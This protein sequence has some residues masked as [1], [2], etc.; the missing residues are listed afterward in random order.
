MTKHSEKFDL[1][2][3]MCGLLAL[4]TQLSDRLE[5]GGND[6][7]PVDIINLKKKKLAVRS[8]IIATSVRSD[9]GP[10]LS[11]ES[12]F[13]LSVDTL[14]L[15][16]EK[17]QKEVEQARRTV[18]ETSPVVTKLIGHLRLIENRL[19]QKKPWPELSEAA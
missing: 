7:T 5:R 1:P 8:V 17:L 9:T 10:R 19:K 13:P 4:H 6:L 11:E 2:K 3:H 16:Q 12:V 18:N 14:Q 15:L